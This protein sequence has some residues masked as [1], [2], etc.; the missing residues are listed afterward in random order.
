[1]DANHYF[2]AVLKELR[3]MLQEYGF[4]RS[5]QH[6]SLET[7]DCWA[8][9]N[10]QKSHWSQPGEK[11]FYV[12]VSVTAKR[13]MAFEGMSIDKAPPYYSCIWRGRAEQFGPDNTLKQW[14]V[15]NGDSLKE[16]V[17]YLHKLLKD[18]VIPAVKS[19]L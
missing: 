16:V 9:I 11:T 5:S 12:N 13:L 1:M 15:S 10:F 3:P 19:M 8:V 4:R 6:F 17:T 18:F 7:P 2:N 14:T